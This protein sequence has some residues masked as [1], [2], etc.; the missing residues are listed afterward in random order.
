MKRQLGSLEDR[1]IAEYSG[2]ISD[3]IE[4]IKNLDLSGIEEPHLPVIGQDY[5]RSKY[6]FAFCGM[7]TKGWGAITEF[8]KKDAESLVTYADYTINNYEYLGWARNYHASFWGFILKFLSKFY[9]V[10]FKDLIDAKHPE[11]LRSF[12]WANANSIERYSV[13]AEKN[14][15]SYD[16]WKKVKQASLPFD[17]LNHIINTANPKVVFILYSGASQD[18]FLDLSDKTYGLDIT[19]KRDYLKI[20]RSLII[21]TFIEEKLP[22]IFSTYPTLSFPDLG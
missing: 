22:P 21:S 11:L 3:F 19:N 10:P 17:N 8:I 14:N 7:E 5:E 9:Q 4:Q 20:I 18:Y 12:V 1:R 15:A 13:S 6:K 2:L 16:S